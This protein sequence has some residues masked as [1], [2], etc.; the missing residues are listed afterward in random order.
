MQFSQTP[1]DYWLNIEYVPGMIYT[2]DFNKEQNEQDPL[3]EVHI[4]YF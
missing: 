2:L 1:N 4:P 3:K